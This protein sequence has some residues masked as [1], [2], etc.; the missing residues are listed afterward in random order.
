MAAASSQDAE[1]MLD[2]CVL[3]RDQRVKASRMILGEP[4]AEHAESW[5]HGT[6]LPSCKCLD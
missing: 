2:K 3:R 5:V 1:H 4:S 6:D